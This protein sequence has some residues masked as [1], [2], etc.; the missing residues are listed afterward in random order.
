MTAAD[1]GQHLLLALAVICVTAWAFGGVARRLG[2]PRVIGEIV[3]GIALGPSVLGALWSTAETQLFP[4]EVRTLLRPI[5]DLGLVLFMF[6][7]GL[8]FDRAHVRG[9]GSRA[10]VVSHTSIV[11]PFVGGA[12]VAWWLHD[13]LAPGFD[14]VPFCL[15]VGAAMAI[16]AFPVLARI[17]QETGLDQT[18]VGALALVCAAIDDV[19]A[20]CILAVVLAVARDTGAGPALVTIGAAVAYGAA[21]WWLVRPLLARLGPIP[22]PVA[23]SLAIGSAWVTDRI[24]IHAIFGAFLAG[25]VLAAQPG[26]VPPGVLHIRGLVDALLLPVFFMIVGLSTRI[27]LLDSPKAWGLAGLV[28]VVAVVGKV[29]GAGLAARVTGAS[30]RDAGTLAVL[31]NTRGLTEIVI[32]TVGLEREII[33]PLTFTIMVLMAL[34]TTV[35]T[36]PALRTLGVAEVPAPGP[37]GGRRRSGELPM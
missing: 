34:A 21:M 37:I 10:V 12:L 1:A 14:V 29:G 25:V 2:Q 3:A 5:A 32:L 17:L 19:T 28:L 16:T 23:L 31:M 13:T 18:R 8:G 15:F 36:V 33:S 35:M 4:A 20:W 11:V 6:L 27:G 30:W 26:A 22:L 9:Q 7:V 24:G